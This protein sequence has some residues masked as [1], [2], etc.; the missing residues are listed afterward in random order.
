MYSS[1]KGDHAGAEVG[2]GTKGR[3][4]AGEQ[5]WPENPNGDHDVRVSIRLC[6]SRRAG[7]NP[8]G[9]PIF[10]RA[11]GKAGEPPVCNPGFTRC[12]PGARVHFARH[13]VPGTRKTA[14]RAVRIGETPGAAP[15][16][17]TNFTFRQGVESDARRW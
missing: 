10:N 15:G 7:A 3:W 17:P 5:R 4:R 2:E 1:C 6:E 16:C 12:E 11:Q 14:I 9:L 13:K 8:V